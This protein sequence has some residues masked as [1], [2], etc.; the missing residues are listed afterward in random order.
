M[1]HS[2]SSLDPR[3]DPVQFTGASSSKNMNRYFYATLLG[4]L[5]LGLTG[6]QLGLTSN[7]QAQHTPQRLGA[8]R[9]AQGCIGSAGYTWSEI[10]GKCLRIFEDGL[11]FYSYADNPQTNSSAYVVLDKGNDAANKAELHLPGNP[12]PIILTLHKP[13]EGE[14]RPVLMENKSQEIEI[15]KAKDDLLIRVK[16]K[17]WF[18]HTP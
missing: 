3:I 15:I 11:A 4:L 1:I 2:N 17:L 7:A 18:V 6:C 12:R 13:M 14:I 10:R 5:H 16:G 9:D 8:D